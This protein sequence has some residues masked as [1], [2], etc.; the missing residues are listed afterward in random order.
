MKK[1]GDILNA[2]FNPFGKSLWKGTW[3]SGSI[4]VPDTDKYSVFL[5]SQNGTPVIA[6]KNGT[7]I[8]GFGISGQNSNN[9]HYTRVFGATCSGSTWNLQFNNMLYHAP[10]SSHG[11]GSSSFITEIIGLVPTWGGTAS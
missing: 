3:S 2:L 6:L 10:S 5:L 4:S 1:I 11:A 8:R 7:T 9:S